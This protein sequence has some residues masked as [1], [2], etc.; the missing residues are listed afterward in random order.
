MTK[1]VISFIKSVPWDVVV[2]SITAIASL[3]L[4]AFV[5]RFEKISKNR[6][7]S[8]ALFDKRYEVYKGF[9]AFFKFAD[10]VKKTDEKD[11]F[12]LYNHQIILDAICSEFHLCGGKDFRS[13]NY[14]LVREINDSSL[15]KETRDKKD[16]ELMWLHVNT[17][18]E[19]SLLKKEIK[20]KLELSEFCF[21]N[22]YSNALTDYI[23][24]L[25]SYVEIFKDGSA[26]DYERD[27]K[28]LNQTIEKIV[29]DQILVN[30]KK[31]IKSISK[32]GAK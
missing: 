4:S 25:F 3:T 26:A 27:T 28:I 16:I 21:D 23:E 18:K 14:R 17:D 11:D 20:T 29:K 31:E 13:E 7:Y 30:M 24:A 2:P 32:K 8:I 15:S 9:C 6:D 19:L 5:F 22:D 10:M 1:T 12:D